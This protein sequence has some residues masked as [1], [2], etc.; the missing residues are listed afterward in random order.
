[1]S[2]SLDLQ[3]AI[4]AALIADAAVTAL[5]PAANIYDGIVRQDHMPAITLGDDM[6][7]DADMT[8]ARDYVRVTSTIHVWVREASFLTA[9]RIVGAIRSA[10]ASRVAGFVDVRFE[11]A[12]FLRDPDGVTAHGVVTFDSLVWSPDA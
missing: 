12:R 4:R 8:L 10:V 2:A 6:E 7:Q 1:V 9:K 5:V 11:S 3:S